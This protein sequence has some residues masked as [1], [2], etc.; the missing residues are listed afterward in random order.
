MKT[1]IDIDM[2]MSD[3][4]YRPHI[5]ERI[6]NKTFLEN[7]PIVLNR[8][9]DEEYMEIPLFRQIYFLCELIVN[10]GPLKLTLT[11]NLPQKVV[12]KMYSL[13]V[14]FYYYEKFPNKL[15]KET[16]SLAVHLARVLAEHS[17]LVKKK[18]KLLV[19]T[20]K[21]EMAMKNR[22]LLLK[23]LLVALGYKLS[24]GCFDG[25]EDKMIGQQGFGQS[26]LMLAR[27]G[28]TPQLSS[29]YSERYFYHY[30]LQSFSEF[31]QS[32]YAHRTFTIFLHNLGLISISD[33]KKYI[34]YNEALITKTSLFDRLLTIDENYGKISFSPSA[35]APLYRLRIGLDESTPYIWR[36]F[37]VPSNLSLENL[38]LVVQAVMGWTDSHLHQFVKGDIQYTCKY[39]SCDFSDEINCVDYKGM[40]VFDL[41][42]VAGETIKYEY[43]FG[44]DWI[45][46]IE[47]LEVIDSLD[48]SLAEKVGTENF[49]DTPLFLRCLAGARC[50]PHEDCGGIDG[51]HNILEIL[52][53]PSHEEYEVNNIW[54]DEDFDPDYFDL[55]AV[56][57]VLASYT[58]PYFF[59]S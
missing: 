47:L 58:L 49:G 46:T 21:G 48:G 28:A 10:E 42:S 14:P 32:C 59:A 15:K 34:N 52:K 20:K 45:H 51:Y 38:H 30:H 54:L 37:I 3:W 12:F 26:L 17:G 1:T 33:E 29:F 16:D 39:E 9:G 22:P 56:N 23:T 6:E 2:V 8:I 43:D 36:E 19:I 13:G 57:C 5:R 11:G 7:G 41:L 18:A 25:Y 35:D 31:P 27:Y 40:K 4:L 50:C 55:K 24:W 44:D 53:D